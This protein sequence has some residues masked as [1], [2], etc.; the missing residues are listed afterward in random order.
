VAFDPIRTGP[1]ISFSR[2][3]AWPAAGAPGLAG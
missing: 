3:S 2:R 1:L